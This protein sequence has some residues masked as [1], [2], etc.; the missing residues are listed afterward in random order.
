MLYAT[1]DL[2]RMVELATDA[3]RRDRM[4][5]LTGGDTLA[6]AEI[7]IVQDAILDGPNPDLPALGRL[8]VHQNRIADLNTR[9]PPNLPAVWATL[10]NP[11]RGETLAHSITT[12]HSQA[13]AL[14]DLVEV[15]A[16][17]GDY[18]PRPRTSAPR[19]GNSLVPA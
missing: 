6:I 9:I 12:P 1:G 11:T 13:E 3:A 10:G 19:T 14:T 15:L 16:V 5:D 8:A 18:R 17:T 7:S 4:L 2:T